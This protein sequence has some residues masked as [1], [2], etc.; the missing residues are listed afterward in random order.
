MSSKIE[1]CVQFVAC[2]ARWG[3]FYWPK[4]L[5]ITLNILAS[6]LLFKR[7]NPEVLL[8]DYIKIIPM[9]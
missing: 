7:Q 4:R 1:I 8:E 6:P 2:Q 9:F 5:A 3:V